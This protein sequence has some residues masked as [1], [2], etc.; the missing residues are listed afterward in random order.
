MVKYTAS[1]NLFARRVYAVCE[2]GHEKM[3]PDSRKTNLKGAANMETRSPFG[4]SAAAALAF[5]GLTAAAENFP[6]G[7]YVYRGSVMNYKH[8]VCSS[9]DRLT[10]QA[11]AA[12]GNVLASCRVTDPV[13]TSGVNFVLEVPVTTEAS[14]KSAAIGDELTCVVRSAAG[15]T[16]V[17]TLAMP[18]VA[19]ANAITNLN[20]VGASATSFT[21]EGEGGETVL[22]SDDYLAGLAPWMRRYGKSEYDPFEDWDGDGASNY[23]EYKAGTNPFDPSDRLRITAFAPGR[24]VATLLS[25]EYA[26][27]HLYALDSTPSLTNLTW[28]A[29]PFG[30]APGEAARQKSVSMPGNEYEDVGVMTLYLAP[31]ADTPSMFY[32]IRAE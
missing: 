3:K 6:L 10:V 21:K 27:G 7:T 16:G 25:F 20:V 1:C 2:K 15:Q 9:A 11:V 4:L 12:N 22:V 29:E 32:T 24:D 17:S 26:G 13:A 23:D 14:S 18:A 31:A 5:L 30:T 8:E 28:M 19:A